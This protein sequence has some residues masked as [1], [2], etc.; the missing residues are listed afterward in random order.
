MLGFSGC[1]GQGGGNGLSADAARFDTRIAASGATLH[2]TG[3]SC[4]GLYGAW[5]VG[6]QVSGVA[7]GSGTT[8]FTLE[9]G[10]EA[11]APVS[12]AIHAGP[13]SGQATGLL[14]V[15][16]RGTALVVTGRVMVKVPFKS[17]SRDISETIPV[18]L[19][20]APGC[21]LSG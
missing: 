15:R 21:G 1:G 18:A 9:R 10:R 8:E 17:L 7:A 13:L 11:Q 14:R 4:S 16:S 2:A 3:L 20:P 5:K 12:F 19:G 6:L